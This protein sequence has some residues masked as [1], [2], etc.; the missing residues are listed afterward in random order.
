MAIL[1]QALRINLTRI[2][3]LHQVHCKG[4]ASQLIS[5][6]SHKSLVYHSDTSLKYHSFITH[7]SPI[8]KK[9]LISHSPLNV[10][11]WW[12]WPDELTWLITQIHLLLIRIKNWYS[13]A[14]LP[15]T[16]HYRVSARTGQPGVSILRLGQIASLICNFYLSAET[17]TIA[18]T[19]LTPK[20]NLHIAVTSSNRKTT[21]TSTR[22]SAMYSK[23]ICSV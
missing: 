20:Y 21:P 1:K 14:A 12:C 8:T 13:V 16:W 18:E 9:S 17:C 22:P 7:P 5:N 2:E 23:H 6:H 3:S 19:D 4:V 15:G 10:Q 11:A